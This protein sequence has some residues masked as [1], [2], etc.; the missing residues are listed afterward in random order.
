[1]AD[2]ATTS[3]MR[4][5]CMGT[6]EEDVLLPF[7]VMSEKEGETLR[8]IFDSLKQFLGDRDKDYRAWDVAGG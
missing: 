2:K 6:I 4:S 7:P 5:L 1:M 8:A 3:F